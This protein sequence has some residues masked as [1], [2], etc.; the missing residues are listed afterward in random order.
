MYKGFVVDSSLIDNDP[1]FDQGCPSCHRGN[2]YAHSRQDAHLGLV[3]RPSDDLASCGDCH[4]DIVGNYRNALHYT[5]AGLRNGIIGRFSDA[6]TE[7][8]DKK[9]FEKSCRSCHASC[10]DCHVKGPEIQGMS[11]GL[12]KKHAFVKKDEKNTCAFC[13]GGRVYPEFTGQYGVVKDVHHTKSMMCMDCHK[14]QEMHG[15]GNRYRS[16]REV[17]DKPTCVSCH[18]QGNEKSEKAADA[19]DKHKGILTCQACHA[20]STYKNCY[21]CHLGKGARSASGF[22]LGLSP[23]D[24]RT[25]TVLRAIPTVRDTFK[26]VGIEMR[27][28]DALPNYWDAMP[29]VIRKSTERTTNCHMCHLVKMGFL[30][31]EKLIKNGSRANDQLL[32]VPRPVIK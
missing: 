22:F 24:K 27:N 12:I 5:T 26:S 3:K 29:H 2:E 15:D 32:Y 1:H 17:A 4:D 6:E 28:Y 19:H 13:H 8:F 14:M 21:N 25:V 10:G 31:R 16:R 18:P 11:I 30:T 7:W 9:V 20:V 23:K